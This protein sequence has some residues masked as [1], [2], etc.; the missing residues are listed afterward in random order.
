VPTS[1]SFNQI[2]FDVNQS[3]YQFSLGPQLT[4]IESEGLKIHIRPT[5]SANIIDVSA[6][7]TET[8]VQTPAGGNSVVIDSWSDHGSHL[9]VSVG[10]GALGGI[11]LDLGKGFFAGAF[12]GYEWVAEKVNVTVGPNVLSA[13]ASGWVAGGLI[14]LKF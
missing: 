12:G 11:D 7:R 13:D 9:G 1:G 4:V 10:L 5:V 8:F 2:D 14:G 3:L 6:Q